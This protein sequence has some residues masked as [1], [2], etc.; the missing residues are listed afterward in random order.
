MLTE[1]ETLDEWNDA[2]GRARVF[3][4]VAITISVKGAV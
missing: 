4:S 3:E 1:V 2:S